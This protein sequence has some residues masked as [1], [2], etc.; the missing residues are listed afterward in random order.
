VLAS[1]VVNAKIFGSGTVSLS[2][3]TI[4]KTLALHRSQCGGTAGSPGATWVKMEGG[5]G[6]PYTRFLGFHLQAKNGRW[7][8]TPESNLVNK[9]TLI[10]TTHVTYQ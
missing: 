8:R 2:V 9:N 6:L 3:L 5:L 1:L 7:F 4:K 10:N